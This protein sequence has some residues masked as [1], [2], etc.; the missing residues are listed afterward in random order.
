M[1]YPRDFEHYLGRRVVRVR[2][3]V[4]ARRACARRSEIV[5]VVQPWI[6]EPVS[7]PC[8]AREG[9]RHYRLEQ[10]GRGREINVWF[11]PPEQ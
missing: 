8:T 6:V 9:A 7:F 11:V 1:P 2:T 5:V 3:T 10:Y 4:D